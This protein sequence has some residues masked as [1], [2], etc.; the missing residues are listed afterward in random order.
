M[1]RSLSNY[2]IRSSLVECG[3]TISVELA[4]EV[5]SMIELGGFLVNDKENGDV[6]V[7]LLIWELYAYVS[8]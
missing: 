4:V 6:P 3:P 7:V 8:G 5:V 1:C 2:G